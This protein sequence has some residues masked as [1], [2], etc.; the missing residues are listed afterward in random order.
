MFRTV[1]SFWADEDGATTVEW[2]VL[3]AG[4]VGLG[5]AVTNLLSSGV[6]KVATSIQAELVA[7]SQ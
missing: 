2:V 1:K 7:D 5:I 4:V 3:C 6:G